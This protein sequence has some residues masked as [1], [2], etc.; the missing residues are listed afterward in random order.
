MWQGLTERLQNILARFRGRGRLS[1]E[2]VENWLR[3]LRLSLI[4][5][6][7]N[8]RVARQFVNQIRERVITPEV[9]EHP[10]PFKRMTQIVYEELVKLLGE[11]PEPLQFS[12]QP[13]TV[14][15]LLGLQGSGK[16]TTCG[17]I[18]LMLKKQGKRPLLV[19]ADLKRPAAIE[20]L[21]QVGAQLDVPV[22]TMRTG[23]PEALAQAALNHAKTNANDMVLVDSAGRLHTDDE[24]M[25]ELRRLKASFRPHESLLVLDATTGQDAVRVAEVFENEVG[26]TGIVLTKLDSDARGGAVLS[27]RAVT[28]KPV[29][30]VGLGE[31]MQDLDVFHPDRMAARILGLGDVTS[32]MERVESVS[33]VDETTAR[34]M[35]ERIA[36]GTFNLEDLLF[37]L[38]QMRQSGPLEQLLSFLPGLSG[39]G[40]P[41]LQIDERKLKRM[42]AIILSMT[43]EE[44]RNPDIIDG[45]RK[46]R[47]ARGSGTTV[48]EVNQILRQFKA[49]RDTMKRLA[50]AK[51]SDKDIMKLLGGF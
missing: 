7:V 26:I 25:D 3:E 37:Q 42:E 17:K 23:S 47:I 43:P 20:Q 30:L 10:N 50:R 40:A 41:R 14:F 8:L 51:I 21:E 15:L 16:T 2:E 31:H 29:K 35:E 36:K 49:M 33:V 18:A 27:V 38:R 22:F 32:L 39:L 44:R 24:L 28:G 11:K 45:S 46:R 19:A 13:P 9:L 48:Q 1:E 6:D 12:S 4:E 5:A 34:K